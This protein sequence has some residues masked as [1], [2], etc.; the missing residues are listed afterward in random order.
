MAEITALL[1]FV[2]YI[3]VVVPFLWS[4]FFRISERGAQKTPLEERYVGRQNDL[5]PY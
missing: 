1:P 4:I 2:I 3:F 5:E